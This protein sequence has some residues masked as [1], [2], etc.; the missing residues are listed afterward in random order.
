M[1]LKEYREA[2]SI[3]FADA[4]KALNISEGQLSKYETGKS[5][6]RPKVMKRIKEWSKNCVQPN[7]F[8]CDA[9][10]KGLSKNDS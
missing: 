10:I 7:D 2:L 5:L 6:P 8:Y 9:A 4:A 3:S 1:K